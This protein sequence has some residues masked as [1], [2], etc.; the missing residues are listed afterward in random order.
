MKKVGLIQFKEGGGARSKAS[1]ARIVNA[2]QRLPWLHTRLS[3]AA[4]YGVGQSLKIG[5][6]APPPPILSKKK[7]TH[8]R[9]W[10]CVGPYFRQDERIIC[11]AYHVIRL[12]II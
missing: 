8:I 9:G 5:T 3:A 11:W 10:V 7:G 2:G 1:K 12:Q 6:Q 4:T